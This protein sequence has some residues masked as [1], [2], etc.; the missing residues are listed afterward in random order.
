MTTMTHKNTHSIAG[1]NT[2]STTPEKAPPYCAAKKGSANNANGVKAQCT[3]HTSVM[4]EP[5]L[6][7]LTPNKDMLTPFA[8]A[9]DIWDTSH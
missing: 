8:E 3:A 1:E 5:A 9:I 2:E 6:E 7:S 4:I